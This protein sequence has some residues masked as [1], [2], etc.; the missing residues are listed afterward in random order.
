[1]V[2]PPIVASSSTVQK[3]LS[4][5][6]IGAGSTKFSYVWKDPIAGSFIAFTSAPHLI[7][8]SNVSSCPPTTVPWRG[9]T[10]NGELSVT[11]GPRLGR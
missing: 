5:L 7:N 11:E 10:K 4:W 8:G 1:M 9:P 6:P 3:R 2:W